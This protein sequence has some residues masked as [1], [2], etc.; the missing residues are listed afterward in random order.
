MK[1]SSNN[2]QNQNSLISSI[3]DSSKNNKL[4]LD[5]NDSIAINNLNFNKLENNAE[6]N[7]TQKM[8][9]LS[10]KSR[11]NNENELGFEKKVRK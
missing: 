3:K 7:R 5:I 6:T 11:R 9:S 1:M 8:N 10:E 4:T 2:A